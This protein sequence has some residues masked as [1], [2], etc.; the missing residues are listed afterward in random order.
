MRLTV[1]SD[2]LALFPVVTLGV[3]A[4]EVDGDR[5]GREE[6]LRNL[7]D[8]ALAGLRARCPDVETLMAQPNVQVWREAYQRFG[9]KPTKFRP[10][11]EALARRLLREP[12]W[13]A[14][15][16]L[17]DV[18]LTNQ[19]AHL[20]PH[21]GYDLDRLAGDLALDRSPGGEPFEPLGGGLEQTE[22]GE[23]G[24]R[25]R[26]RVLTRRWNHR[27]A[28]STKIATGTRRFLLFVE[29]VE[30]IPAAAVEDAIADLARRLEACFEGRFSGRTFQVTSASREITLD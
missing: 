12:A 14:I 13:P 20:L 1:G 21:G 17:V 25:D 15:H 22:P 24:Y 9:T 27:D 3:L 26:E 11:H 18:Y 4:G 7:Q 2:L 5:P 16:P 28:D 29:A 23:V 6:M 30:G 19:I 8:E 10:T